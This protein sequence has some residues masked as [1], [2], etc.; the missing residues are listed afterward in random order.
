MVEK[1]DFSQTGYVLGI[2]SI[3]FAFFNP[4]IGLITGVIGYNH[5]RKQKTQL[6]VKARRFNSVG[7]G[8]SLGLLVLY[9]ALMLYLK[10]KGI[11]F[12]SFADFPA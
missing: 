10:I 11:D 4:L 12:S 8:I 2:L 6:S 1:K 5:V 7:I 9:A 3:V